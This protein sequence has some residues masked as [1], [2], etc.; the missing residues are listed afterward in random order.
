MSEI[1]SHLSKWEPSRTIKVAFLV[2]ALLSL[3]AVLAL[4]GSRSLRVVV[5]DQHDLE[6]A[7]GIDRTLRPGP[8]PPIALQDRDGKPVTLEQFR[9]RV[10]FVN[11]WATWCGPCREEMPSLGELARSM[12]PRDTVFLAVSVDESWTPIHDF[13]GPQVLPYTV[14]L[15]PEH[16]VSLRY[17]TS[18]F[19]ESYVVD[20]EGNLVYK[21]IGAR[22]WSSP[23]ARRILEHAG[24]RRLPPPAG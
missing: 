14:L 4:Y 6:E 8:A 23:F 24:A 10:V 21:F 9:G 16:E 3:L 15:D 19:P 20:R 22:D 13:L 17:G 5:V 11:F 12:D 7:M 1:P 18:Q 2:V